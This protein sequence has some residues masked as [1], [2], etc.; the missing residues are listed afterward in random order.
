M[1]FRRSNQ[2]FVSWTGPHKGRSIT[3]QRLPHWV[4]EVMALAHASQGLQPPEGP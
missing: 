1:G 4:E 2:L 3:K